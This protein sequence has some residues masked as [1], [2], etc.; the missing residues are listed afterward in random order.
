MLI[1]AGLLPLLNS[2]RMTRLPEMTPSSA[3]E[4]TVIG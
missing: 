2:F 3:V 4:G 1:I